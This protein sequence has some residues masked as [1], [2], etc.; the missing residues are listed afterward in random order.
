MRS[1]AALHPPTSKSVLFQFRSETKPLLVRGLLVA[2]LQLGVSTSTCCG[3]SWLPSLLVLYESTLRIH[4]VQHELPTAMSNKNYQPRC[5][6]SQ[7]ILGTCAR[8]RLTSTA[9]RSTVYEVYEVFR[10]LVGKPPSHRTPYIHA[11]G[12]SKGPTLTDRYKVHVRRN[13]TAICVR[14]LRPR[15]HASMEF[16]DHWSGNLSILLERSA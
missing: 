13:S 10:P 7:R 8:E 9:R 12:C 2:D 14:K 4:V 1:L 6:W 11:A 3:R 5:A 16:S 15:W